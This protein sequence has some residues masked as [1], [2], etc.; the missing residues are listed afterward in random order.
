MEDVGELTVSPG[1]SDVSPFMTEKMLWHAFHNKTKGLSRWNGDFEQR[2][3]L[4][5]NCYPLASDFD[6]DMKEALHDF[7]KWMEEEFGRFYGVLWSERH[8]RELFP[9]FLSSS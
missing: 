2:W 9:I 8:D 5:L 6:E 3:L 4:L 1:V 7:A